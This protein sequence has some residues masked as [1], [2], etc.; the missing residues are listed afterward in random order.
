[1]A[2]HAS[3]KVELGSSTSA[4]RHGFYFHVGRSET[5]F[6]KHVRVPSFSMG[7]RFF[8]QDMPVFEP[9]ISRVTAQQFKISS[10]V[11]RL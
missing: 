2:V 7:Q 5:G 11:N 6:S 10:E 1:M 4:A 3:F 8:Y 9:V